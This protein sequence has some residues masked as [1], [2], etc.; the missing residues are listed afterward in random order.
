MVIIDQN[1]GYQTGRATSVARALHHVLPDQSFVLMRLED[2]HVDTIRPPEGMQE[3]CVDPRPSCRMF[4]KYVG[5]DQPDTV[6][7][8]LAT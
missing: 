4:A 1:D 3:C 6:L 8:S 2:H 7:H 5:N